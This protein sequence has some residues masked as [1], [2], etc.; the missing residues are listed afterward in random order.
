MDVAKMA[1]MT[2]STKMAIITM[3][4]AIPRGRV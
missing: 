3:M 4:S 2:D 1:A